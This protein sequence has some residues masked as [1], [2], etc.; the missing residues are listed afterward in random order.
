[1][2]VGRVQTGL[3]ESNEGRFHWSIKIMWVGKWET[4]LKK[5]SKWEWVVLSFKCHSKNFGGCWGY[6]GEPLRVIKQKRND[7]I[8]LFPSTIF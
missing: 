6:N 3:M 4:E 2:K 1:M 7:R 8:G 5:K